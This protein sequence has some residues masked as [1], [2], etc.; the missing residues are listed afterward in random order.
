MAFSLTKVGTC[1]EINAEC[2]KAY[3]EAIRIQEECSHP[4]ALEW[5][6]KT[7]DGVK[8]IKICDDCHKQWEVKS[9]KTS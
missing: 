9:E 3:H 8:V 6:I 7:V 4:K 1:E 5:N 2:W